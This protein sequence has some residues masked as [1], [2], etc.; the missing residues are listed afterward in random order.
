MNNFDGDTESSNI[1]LLP[2]AHPSVSAARPVA[3]QHP[4]GSV[5]LKQWDKQA[6]EANR[7]MHFLPAVTKTIWVCLDVQSFPCIC[8]R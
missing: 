2:A 1:H 6:V 5:P 8:R 7:Q 4:I 3:H